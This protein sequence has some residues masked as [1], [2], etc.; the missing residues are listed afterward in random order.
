MEGG[1]SYMKELLCI[2]SV[3]WCAVTIGK[4]F[5][6]TDTKEEDKE[7]MSSKSYSELSGQIDK[8]NRYKYGIDTINE[9]YNDIESCSPGKV[10]KNVT[11]RIEES[12]RE[13][14]FLVDGEDAVSQ[15]ILD[16]FDIK[17][18]ELSTSLRSEVRKIS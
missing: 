9:M 3:L 7:V 10:L 6:K 1:G 2:L 17:R 16:I 11:I 12:G 5:R 8:L 4:G 14:S 18:D 15:N 13:Y